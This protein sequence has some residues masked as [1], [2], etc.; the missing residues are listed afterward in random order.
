MFFF[1]CWF[2]CCI[3]TLRVRSCSFS[4]SLARGCFPANTRMVGIEHLDFSKKGFSSSPLE[5]GRRLVSLSLLLF[6]WL[7]HLRKARS[8]CPPTNPPSQQPMELLP[9]ESFLMEFFLMEFFLVPN[10]RAAQ[11]E[12]LGS[13]WEFRET[14]KPLDTERVFPKWKQEFLASGAGASS[15]SLQEGSA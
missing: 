13:P 8:R 3:E 14:S 4:S 15:G 12:G 9:M 1:C 5:G 6:L 2:S 10:L 7:H 11:G